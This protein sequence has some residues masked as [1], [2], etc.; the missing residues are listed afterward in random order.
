MKDQER[1]DADLLA[2]FNTACAKVKTAEKL[3]AAKAKLRE[4]KLEVMF[5]EAV[6]KSQK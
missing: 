3:A 1:H 2:A 6:A 5:W 4:A